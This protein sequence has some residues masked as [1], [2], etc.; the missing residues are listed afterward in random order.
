[1][2]R[3]Q[4]FL[5]MDGV[6]ADFDK[7][8]ELSY[9]MSPSDAREKL[10]NEDFWGHILG[11]DNFFRALPV[12][13][14]SKQA[15]KYFQA[16]GYRPVFLTGVPHSDPTVAWQK[17]RWANSHFKGVP[18]HCCFSREKSRFC[19]EGDVLLD[20]RTEYAGRWID[21]GGTF[22]HFEGNWLRS[23]GIVDKKMEHKV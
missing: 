10:S 7:G 12:M 17:L 23:M 5:D 1:M 2:K 19:Q 4:L 22:V 6:F 13:E 8:F 11:I 18:V 3:K 9:G 15:M 21:A 20:D 14:G 16:R